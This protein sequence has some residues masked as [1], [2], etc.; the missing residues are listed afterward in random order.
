MKSSPNKSKRFMIIIT[1]VVMVLMMLIVSMVSAKNNSGDQASL[2]QSADARTVHSEA[3]NDVNASTPTQQ[4]AIENLMSA[5]NNTA[6]IAMNN[7]T[8]AVRFASFPQ[9]LNS[10]DMATTNEASA[11]EQADAFLNRYGA[12]FG[13]NDVSAQLLYA[14]TI[15]DMYGFT[16]VNYVEVHEGVD[17]FASTMRV[18]FNENGRLTAVNGTII[19]NIKVN[20]Q[21]NLTPEEAAD[22]AAVE[23]AGQQTTKTTVDQLTVIENNLYYYNTGL[24]QSIPGDTVLAYE[25]EVSDLQNIREFVFVDAHSGNIVDQFTGIHEGTGADREISETSLAN[26]VWDESAGNPDPIPVGWASGTAQQVTDW[27]NEIDGAKETYNTI[28]N[29]TG[30]TY[31]SYDGAEATMRTV[32]NDPGIS[33]P[34]ANWN[35]ISTNYCSNVT[36]DDTVAH[37]WGHAY[38][39]YTHNLIYAW[40]PGALNESYSDIWGEIVDLINGRGA[41]TPGG[42]RTN[43]ACSVYGTGTPSTDN[44]YRWLSGEDDPAFG[45]AIRDMWHPNCYGD[46]GK[47]SDTQYWCTSDDGGGVHTNS[48]VPNHAFALLV[49]GGTYNGQTISG[50]GLDKAAHI[51]WRS[52]TIYQSETTDFVDHASA[53]AQ[54]C[55]DLVGQPITALSAAYSTTVP[56]ASITASDCLELDKVITAVE[57]NTAPTQCGFEPAFVEAPPLCE[58]QGTGVVNSIYTQTWESGYTGWVTGTHDIANPSSFTNPDWV[59]RGSLPGSRLGNAMY[60]EDSIN[61]G[62][63]TPA[64]TVAGALNLDSPTF[65]VPAGSLVTRVAIDHLVATEAGWDG[66]NVKISVN[67]GGWT[68]LPDSVF[69]VNGY[70][71]P[72]AINGGGNDNPLAGEAGF[73]G[74]GEGSISTG[75]GQSQLDLSGYVSPGDTFKLRFDMG[76]D[77]CNGVDGWYV[78]DFEVYSCEGETGGAAEPI[79]EVNPDE[80]SSSQVTDKQITKTLTISNVGTLD[81]DWEI[82][83]A[84]APAPTFASKKYDANIVTDSIDRVGIAT[85]ASADV[86]AQ[87]LSNPQADVVTDGGFEAGPSGGTWTEASTNFGTPI[88]DVSSCGTGTGTG[89]HTGTYW[90]WFGG[91]GTYEEGSVSQSVT[92]PNGSATLTFWL[93]QIVCDSANDYMEVTIDGNQI[94]LTDG[95]SSLCGILGYT[96]QSVDVSAYADGGTHTLTFHSEIFATNGGGSN[97]FLDDVVLDSISGPCSAP[98]DIPW[99]SVNPISG[100]VPSLSATDVDVVFDSTGMATGTYT[101]T[102]CINSNDT[103]SSLVTVPVAMNVTDYTFI[104]LPIIMKP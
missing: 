61:R 25:V 40:Q 71:A 72:G 90:T 58:N 51:Y 53:I 91:I 89:P 3:A 95:N 84:A 73:T 87:I 86:I 96:Q 81:L 12:A 100:T 13:L 104:Y 4:T 69:D 11:K 29:L 30:G 42:L 39:E 23:V 5:S 55:T 14:E 76:L 70:Y 59:I 44:T 32:N 80:L 43:G 66:G 99:V 102:L 36:G 33:C 21:P 88:C 19:P 2:T 65:T 77:G 54:S 6:K 46:P 60:V 103:A 49:D 1:I 50:I 93:E 97:F 78:D 79:I 68:V 22:I 82:E 9:G 34:N 63:C 28:D 16:H 7:A 47:V 27:Q 85:S 41:D 37:E 67:G 20:A 35:G 94:F 17:V 10:F 64:D 75:W 26:V 15:V 38:T 31:S 18:H 62:A 74:G 8:N 56:T 24:L 98:A 45:G 57:F 48:G 101:G 52:Q 83:E 92:I